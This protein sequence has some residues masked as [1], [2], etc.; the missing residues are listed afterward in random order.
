MAALLRGAVAH[1]PFAL[2]VPFVIAAW[3][4]TPA[5]LIATSSFFAFAALL[6][7]LM[8]IVTTTYEN[9]QPAASLAQALDDAERAGS[10]ATPRRAE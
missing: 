9:A 7:A 8:W 10:A 5:T 2:A 6:M 3:A 1:R 4:V